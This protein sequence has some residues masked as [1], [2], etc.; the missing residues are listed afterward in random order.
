[1]FDAGSRDLRPG[2]SGEI[3][4]LDG[5][6]IK[7]TFIMGSDSFGRDIY[8]RV[9]YGTRVSLLVGAFSAAVALAF[10]IVLGLV[11]G[12]VR[13]LDGPLMRVMDGINQTHGRQTIRLAG[14]GLLRGWKLRSELRSPHYTTDWND[15]LCVR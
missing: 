12:Y 14:S 7:H 2:E 8:S 13:W 10:G 1:M 3:T 6:L 9:L 4:T 5:D 15:L 11:S